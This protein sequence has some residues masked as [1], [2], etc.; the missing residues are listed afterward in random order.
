MNFTQLLCAVKHA[1][2]CFSSKIMDG[3]NFD[4]LESRKG[5]KIKKYSFEGKLEVIG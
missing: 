3:N 2:H 4:A 1:V 5:H